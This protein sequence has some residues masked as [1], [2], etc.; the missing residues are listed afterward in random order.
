MTAYDAGYSALVVHKQADG[1]TAAAV[2]TLAGA[3]LPRGNVTIRVAYSSLNYKDAL[4]MR[5]HPGVTT[6][7]PHVP[8][9]DA[10]GTVLES[11]S[12]QFPVGSRVVVTGFE[13]GSSHWG[14]YAEVTRVPAEWL[15]PLPAGLSEREAMALGT[16]GFTAAQSLM[17]LEHEGLRPERGKVVVTGSTGGVGSVAIALLVKLGYHAVAV[18]GKPSEHGL[19]ERLG[20]KEILPREALHDASDKPLLKS[21]WAGAID[22]VGG[23][24][25]ATLVRS[26]EPGGCVTACGLVGGT[27]LNLTVYPF[28]LRGAK[29][30]GIDSVSASMAER[31]EI[32]RR[33]AGPWKVDLSSFTRE[34]GLSDA[35]AVAKELLAGRG[36]GRTV[37]RVGA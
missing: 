36:V 32:W 15:A 25:L 3:N 10:A 24:T 11:D 28:I 22:S 12:E 34:I 4:S 33:L 21:R 19:L 1:K 37:V 31:S 5:G 16:A 13:F 20:V 23:E 35:A 9:I 14:G 17:A 29:L 27:Q 8:G 30:V 26:L 18:T 6:V 7:F 2:E